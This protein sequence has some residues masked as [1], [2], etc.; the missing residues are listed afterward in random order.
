MLS[1]LRNVRITI[2]CRT[3][4]EQLSDGVMGGWMPGDAEG[5]MMA[6]TTGTW[7]KMGCHVCSKEGQQ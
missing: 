3:T 7:V 6:K 5:E 2:Q 1:Y 4:N